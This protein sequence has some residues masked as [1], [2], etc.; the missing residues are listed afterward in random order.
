[1]LRLARAGRQE[2]NEA[3]GWGKRMEKEQIGMIQEQCMNNSNVSYIAAPAKAQ[4]ANVS[5]T[6]D[7]GSTEVSSEHKTRKSYHI[8]GTLMK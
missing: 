1:M 7:V 8:T 4:A 3:H 2:T 5:E 6:A